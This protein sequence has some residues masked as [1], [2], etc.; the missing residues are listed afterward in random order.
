M[1][2]VFRACQLNSSSGELG[3]QD[4]LNSADSC[5][6]EDETAT[7]SGV[8]FCGEA[9]EKGGFNCGPS[10]IVESAP[11]TRDDTSQENRRKM[12]K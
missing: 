3:P 5:D 12:T 8:G 6:E 2:G 11:M 10:G 1:D 4:I 7:R 9:R